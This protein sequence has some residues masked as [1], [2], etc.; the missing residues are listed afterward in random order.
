MKGI[1]TF[2]RSPAIFFRPGGAIYTCK[3]TRKLEIFEPPHQI[4]ECCTRFIGFLMQLW[5]VSA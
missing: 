5:W 4:V 2:G 3:G 1:E